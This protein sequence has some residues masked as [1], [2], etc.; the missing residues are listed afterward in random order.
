MTLRRPLLL[1]GPPGVSKTTMLRVLAGRAADDRDA[2]HWVTGDEQLSAHVLVGTFDP[3]LVLREGY[4]AEHFWP[5]PLVRAMRDGGILYIEEL[6]RAPSGA[7]NALITALSERYV[8]VAHLGRVHA[9]PGFMV[10]G[11]ANPLDDIGT[12]RLSRGLMDR[13]LVLE[14][15]YQPRDEEIEIVLREAPAAGRRLAAFAVDLVRRTRHHPEL[16]TG[17]RSGRRSTWPA[18]WLARPAC[19]ASRPTRHCCAVWSARH[20]PAG[21]GCGPLSVVLHVMWSWSCS[22]AW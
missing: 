7:L 20:S 22:Q 9:A 19:C 15:D 6:N 17:R 11:S 1:L 12:G 14:V 2:V 10:V 16:R 8:D 5:G 4:R 3:A 21:S 18:C 13:F